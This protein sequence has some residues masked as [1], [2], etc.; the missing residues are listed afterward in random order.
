MP[1]EKG[2]K[3]FLRE[4]KMREDILDQQASLQRA[5]LEASLADGISWGMGEDAIIEEAE[6]MILLTCGF[7]LKDDGEEVTW[8]T[9]KGQL[10]EKQIKTRDKITK[11]MEKIAHMKKEIDAIRAKDVSQ[12]GLTQGQQTQIARNGQRTEQILVELE[13]LEETLNESIRESLGA[14]VGKL[15][16]GKK[17][18]AIE[19]EE[20]LLR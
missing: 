8:Q 9:Y 4:Y 19:E 18:G 1:P 16:R 10:S 6:K 15:S 20:E 2:L 14:R 11:R 13:N 3:S 12:G 17:K 7:G 5:R